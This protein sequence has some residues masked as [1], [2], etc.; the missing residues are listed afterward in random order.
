MELK[1]RNM[2]AKVIFNDIIP[3]RG[4]LAMCLWPFIFVRNSA[5][6]RYDT[7]ADNHEHIHAEQ[8]KELL[9]VGVMLSA[10]GF[11]AGFGW[12]SLLFIP[13]FFWWYGIE[14]LFRFVQYGN[15]GKAYRNV[16]F[17][18]EAYGNEGDFE[19]L[20]SR[21]AFSWVSHL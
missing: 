13:L 20:K 2:K 6:S 15:A 3:F 14:W 5:A 16:S 10:V 21:K 11:L 19:Y 9:A 17:E 7:T 18:R 8:Q 12:W 1:F 4:F